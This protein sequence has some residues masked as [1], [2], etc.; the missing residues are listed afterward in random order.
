MKPKVIKKDEQQQQ[1]RE[2]PRKV[3]LDEKSR[4]MRRV[5]EIDRRLQ[6]A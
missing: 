2:I 4:L 6:A 1:K 3:L 5:K